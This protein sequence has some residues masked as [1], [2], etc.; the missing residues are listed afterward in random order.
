MIT[1]IQGLAQE[2]SARGST[3]YGVGGMVRN[4]LLGLPVSDYDLCSDMLPEKVLSLAESLG[5]QAGGSGVAMGMVELHI[6]DTICQHTT[7]RTESYD[8]GCGHKPNN[9]AYIRSLSEDAKRRDFT[10]N[11]LYA[12][13]LTGDIIDP[14]GGLADLKRRILRAVDPA[15]MTRDGVRILRMV[16][17]GAELGFDI[18]PATLEAAG[19]NIG[20]VRDISPRWVR[21]EL[22]RILLSDTMYGNHGIVTALERL[23]QLGLLDILLPEVA[24]GR[25]VKQRAD[26]HKYDV[27]NHL[28][29]AAEEAPP[30]L[31]LRLAG[32]LHDIGKPESLR[33]TGRMFKHDKIG[34]EKA[35]SLLARLG[36]PAEITEQVCELIRHHMYDLRGQAKDTTLRVW[37]V[38]R[39]RALTRGLIALRRADVWGSGNETGP[40]A[41]ADRWEQVLEDMEKRGAPF[42]ED[43]LKVTGRDI[44]EALG[45][46]PGPQVG[47]VKRGLLLHC[48]RVPEDNRRERLLKIARDLVN[49]S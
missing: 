1:T 13:I 45:L 37:M 9:V 49:N 32:L 4:P 10:V 6:G 27:M 30:E 11:T 39:G 3:L 8:A 28:F 15:T 2:F 21:Y 38:L 31:T 18:D 12:D 41:T 44:M 26:Y 42:S 48:A 34:A 22:N 46:P 17:F 25:G 35:R 16:R 36:Y 47:R 43:E 20:L 29:H 23:E 7:F 24:E 33:T 14:L 19:Q 40:V 5:I